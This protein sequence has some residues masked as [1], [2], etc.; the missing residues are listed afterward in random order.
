MNYHILNDAGQIIASFMH[1]C[2]RDVCRR[3]F[4]EFYSNCEF[5]DK[6][7]D[8]IQQHDEDEKIVL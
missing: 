7:E 4:D 5:T 6:D 3:A 2:D 8:K 1:E